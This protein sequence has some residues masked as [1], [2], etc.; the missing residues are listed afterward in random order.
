M[1]EHVPFL[2]KN[3]IARTVMV[4]LNLDTSLAH[5]LPALLEATVLHIFTVLAAGFFPL[6]PHH[7]DSAASWKPTP[8]L[9]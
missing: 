9:P 1:L 2:G 7:C 4:V 8:Y 5:S 6:V 3:G